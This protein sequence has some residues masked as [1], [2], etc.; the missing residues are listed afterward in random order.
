MKAGAVQVTAL[1]TLGDQLDAQED[2]EGKLK[3][4]SQVTS[5]CQV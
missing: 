5:T 1:L 4:R 2:E 3:H